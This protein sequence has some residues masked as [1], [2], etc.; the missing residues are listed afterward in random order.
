MAR[1]LFYFAKDAFGVI[2][3]FTPLAKYIMQGLVPTHKTELSP[4][5]NPVSSDKH[6][7]DDL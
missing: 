3:F 7:I 5:I 6:T 1:V 2:S 4:N